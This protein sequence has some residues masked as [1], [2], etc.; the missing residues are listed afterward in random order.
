[1]ENIKPDIEYFFNEPFKGFCGHCN[2]ILY[3][4]GTKANI[5]NVIEQLHECPYCQTPIDWSCF[6]N[7]E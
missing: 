5:P 6:T 1:M 3:T 7:A 2:R 4:G